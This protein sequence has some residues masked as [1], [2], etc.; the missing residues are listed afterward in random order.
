MDTIGHANGPNSV[1]LRN[2]I[3]QFDSLLLRTLN[4]IEQQPSPGINIMIFSDHGMAERIG[5][6]LDS[7]SGLIHVLDYVSESDWERVAG[8]REGPIMQIWPKVG[9]LDAVE[10]T[11]NICFQSVSCFV[12][13]QFGSLRRID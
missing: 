10:N 7:Q 3:L 8:S 5:G 11:S 1:E 12:C 9:K 4:A 13:S 6:P 2:S